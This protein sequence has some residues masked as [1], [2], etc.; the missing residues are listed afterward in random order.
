[1][2]Y[3]SD[4]DPKTFSPQPTSLSSL[5]SSSLRA[6]NPALVLK[7]LRAHFGKKSIALFR[8][9]DPSQE[10][11]FTPRLTVIGVDPEEVLQIT[12]NPFSILEKKLQEFKFPALRGLPFFQGGAL[13]YVA[14]DSVRFLEPTL[15][16][17]KPRYDAEIAFYR[18]FILF[19]HLENRV[20]LLSPRAEM[21]EQL[22]NLEKVAEKTLLQKETVI[23]AELLATPEISTEEMKSGLGRD[24]YLAGVKKLKHHIL[25]GDI[26]QAVISDHFSEKF[27]GDSLDLFNIL[28]QISPAP[29]QFYF[30]SEDRAYLGASPE[31]L[32]KA[33]GD[34]IETHPIAGTRPRGANAEEE[35][36]QEKE[37]FGSI[38]EKAEHLMLVDLARNDLGRVS[39]PGTVKV[40]SFMK[41]RKFGGVMHLVSTV[42][43]KLLNKTSPLSALASCFPA[44]TLSG[45]PKIRAMELISEIE[46]QPRGFYG[47]AF[48]AASFTGDIDSCI[49]IRS[50]SIEDGVARIQAGAGIVADSIPEMEYEEV[51]HKSKLT[52]KALAIA[53]KMT[54][55]KK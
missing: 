37:L 11:R 20:T 25:E 46:K 36:K 24:A 45:A 21:L 52:R 42:T 48:L 44:G 31:M 14:Y 41:L 30:T 32:L 18:F 12:G 35:I 5:E 13:G 54:E 17:L 3:S 50:I 16:Q 28:S 7:E 15:P 6:A 34:Q 19:D 43:G 29:Y 8:V 27:T 47:G 38:K 51:Q 49:S 33:M 9:C 39:A 10:G 26:F 40:D 22:R 55:T 23:S 4:V 53:R 2:V 1:M